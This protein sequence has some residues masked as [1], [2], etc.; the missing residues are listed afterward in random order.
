MLDKQTFCAI[1][2]HQNINS[3]PDAGCIDL[4]PMKR[5]MNSLGE[6]T[7]CQQQPQVCLEN[8]QTSDHE[9]QVH[10]TSATCGQENLSASSQENQSACDQ[11]NKS[12]S[13][14]DFIN[15][16]DGELFS[17]IMQCTLFYCLHGTA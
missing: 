1:S 6:Q 10:S 9:T 5:T 4:N 17:L 13:Y 12:A 14:D 16:H 15:S 7:N 2:S 8:A 3:V 11:E